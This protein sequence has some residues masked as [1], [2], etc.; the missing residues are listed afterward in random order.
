[1]EFNT[2]HFIYKN[3]VRE[4]GKHE[5]LYF[6]SNL[7]SIMHNEYSN[8]YKKK[9]RGHDLETP[10]YTHPIGCAYLIMEDNNSDELNYDTRFK[11]AVAMIFHDVVEDTSVS[12][13]DLQAIISKTLGKE[14]LKLSEDI[15]E[16][17]KKLTLEP[18]L[19]SL[20]E[21]EILRKHSK[22]YSDEIFY[23]KLVDKYFNMLGSSA[24]LEKKGILTQYKE[25]ILFLINQVKSGKFKNS[26]FVTQA[27]KLIS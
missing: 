6:L 27:E 10:Y 26:F 16:L 11:L 1:M 5:R 22:K 2:S 19:G 20:E 14:N 12:F 4:V 9:F 8:T 18:N 24:Y 13:E 21:F 17:I 15:L 25:F 7:A 23:L 3:H